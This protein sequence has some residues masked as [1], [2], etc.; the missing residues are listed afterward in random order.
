[1]PM[2]RYYVHNLETDKLNIFTGGKSDWLSISAEDRERIKKACLWSRSINGWVSRSK[3]GKSRFYALDVLERN[4]FE[5]RGTEGER[6]SFTEQIEAEQDRAARR[7]DRMEE[8]AERAESASGQLYAHAHNMAD[9]IPFG[10]PILIGHYSE[11]RDRRFRE[12]ISNT[13]SRAFEE[14]DKAKYYERRAETARQS[15]DGSKYRDPRYL[16]NRL[17]EIKAEITLLLNRL[18][19]KFY[20][21]DAPKPIS[22]ADRERITGHL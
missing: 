8:R 16:G 22:D 7:A 13:F 17:R 14:G 6:L 11:G 9:A 20:H 1:M 15:A 4:G 19:G 3:G 10:Q 18:Q 12:R 2:K 5:D 21:Y